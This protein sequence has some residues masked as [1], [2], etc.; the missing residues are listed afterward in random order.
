[1]NDGG[2]GGGGGPPFSGG[3]RSMT[4][5]AL[6]PPPMGPPPPR[7]DCG[8]YVEERGTNWEEV[9]VVL[10]VVPRRSPPG[11]FGTEP[12]PP[13]VARLFMLLITSAS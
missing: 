13:P 9:D 7:I 1:M 4:G 2:G 6:V 8:P 11:S 10:V 3:D 5:G 12:R